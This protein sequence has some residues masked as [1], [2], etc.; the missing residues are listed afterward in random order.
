VRLAAATFLLTGCGIDPT[1][2]SVSRLGDTPDA[3]GPYRVEAIVLD[4]GADDQVDLRYAIDGGERI[5]VAMDDVGDERFVADVPGT[6][7]PRAIAYEVA[8]VRDADDVARS[9]SFR[10]DVLDEAP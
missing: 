7:A 9:A 5:G 2:A 8:V 4:L 1:I 10:F 3:V 6:G